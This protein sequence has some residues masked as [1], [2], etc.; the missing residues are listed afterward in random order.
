MAGF[1]RPLR[2][3]E[4]VFAEAAPPGFP[5]GS[6]P[7]V[8]NSLGKTKRLTG[9]L[10][11]SRKKAKQKS[12][13]QQNRKA[14]ASKAKTQKAQKRKARGWG[15]PAPLALRF[16]YF[17]AGTGQKQYHCCACSLAGLFSDMAAPGCWPIGPPVC[18]AGRRRGL[19]APPGIWPQ[20]CGI[21]KCGPPPGLPADPRPKGDA[22]GPPCPAA[23]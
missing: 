16:F 15:K 20:S 13:S 10:P 12:A 22:G 14:K 3:I 8:E 1:R 9:P 18:A 2:W 23:F 5:Q 11:Q 4:P 19:P 21:P 17:P 7:A 6:M